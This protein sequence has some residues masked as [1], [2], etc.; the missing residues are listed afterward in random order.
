M[1]EGWRVREGEARGGGMNNCILCI[2]QIIVNTK[3]VI[4]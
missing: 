1:G 2:M 3:N 4:L